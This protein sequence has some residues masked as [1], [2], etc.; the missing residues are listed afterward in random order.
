LVGGSGTESGVSIA[1][2]SAG[3][4]YITGRTSSLDFPIVGPIQPVYG[5]GDSDAFVRSW[6]LM[7]RC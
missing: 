1:G 6:P 4:A 7:E 2:D 3:N 5:G